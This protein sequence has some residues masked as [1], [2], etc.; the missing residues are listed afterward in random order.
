MAILRLCLWCD[1]CRTRPAAR[2][3]DEGSVALRAVA[4]ILQGAD[5]E[6]LYSLGESCFARSSIALFRPHLPNAKA[7]PLKTR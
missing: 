2:K 1:E 6:R 4:T 5:K 7:A 3:Y